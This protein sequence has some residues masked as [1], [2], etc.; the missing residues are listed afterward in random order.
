MKARGTLLMALPNKDQLKFHSYQDAKLIMEAIEKRYGG[1][2]ESKKVQ[3]TLLKQ[4]YE[5]FAASSS[6]TLDQTF[7]SQPNSPQLAREDLEQINP[8]D[9]EEIDLHW[10]M[11]MLTIRARRALVI[12]LHNKTPYELIRGR[13]SLI[14]FT[15]P[16]GCPITILNTRDS[17]GKFNGKADEGFFIGYSMVS[18]AMRVFNKRIRI[19]EETLNIRFLENAPNM[20]GNGP[21]SLFNIDS[22]TISMNYEPV[23]TRKQTNGLKKPKITFTRPSFANTASPPHINV[24]ATPASTNVFEEH[25]F[26]RFSPFKNV[27]SLPHVPI[28]TLIN[29]T[30]IFGNAYDDEV[31]EEEKSDG[32]FISQEKF[33]ADILKKFDFTTMKIASTLVEHN[34]ALVKDAEAKDVAVHLYR[35]MIGSLMYLTASRPNITFVVYA[36]ARDSSFDL[37]AYSDSN[38]GGASLDRKS[39]TGEYVAAASCCGQADDCRCCSAAEFIPGGSFGTKTLQNGMNYELPLERKESF[40]ESKLLRGSTNQVGN[41]GRQLRFLTLS[42]KLRKVP[43]PSYDLLPNGEDRLQLNELMDICIKLSYRVLSLEQTKTNQATE[44]EKLKKIVK[45]LEGKKK[46]KRTDGLKRLYKV[47][48]SAKVESSKDEEGLGAQ[49]DASKQRRIAEIDANEDLFVSDETAQDQGR[50]KHQDLFGVHDLDG[51]EVFVDFT[52]NDDVE[53]D[54]TVTESVKVIATATTLQIFKDELTLA[55]T[56]MEIK[57]AKHKTKRVTIQ[58]PCEFRTTSSLQPSQPPQDKDKGKGIMVELKK[59]LKKKDQIALDEEVSR[60]LEAEM[61]AE[62]SEE[63]RIAREKNEAKRAIIEE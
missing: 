22:L 36:C 58:E 26:E 53:Q 46:K 50:I 23:V 35:S 37:E 30:G 6:E 49:E 54:T 52:T 55:Q 14:D 47:G 60:K 4:Q 40:I 25:P 27:F 12:K 24:A 61:K 44:I 17:Q 7:D 10:E 15:K 56:W 63:E 11:A 34:K 3:I 19:V 1:N 62:M 41:R 8:D 31:V 13:P 45:E 38:Y 20:K 16:F 9:L 43:T 32:I 28:V 39:T 48:L 51:D 18:K 29:D 57:D 59:P 42:H 2:K 21:N 5:N 33:M